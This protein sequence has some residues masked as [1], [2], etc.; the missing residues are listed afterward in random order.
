MLQTYV[1]FIEFHQLD[2]ELCSI[3]GCQCYICVQPSFDVKVP[4]AH[5]ELLYEV[6]SLRVTCSPLKVVQGTPLKSQF[7]GEIPEL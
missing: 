1:G 2:L 4:L 7:H 5:K 6:P 3:E